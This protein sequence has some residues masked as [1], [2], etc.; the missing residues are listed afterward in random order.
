MSD[1]QLL[2]GQEYEKRLSLVYQYTQRQRDIPGATTELGNVGTEITPTDANASLV[3][4]FNLSEIQAVLESYVLV[5]PGRVNLNLPSELL[6]V[7]CLIEKQSSSGSNS[8]WGLV[9]R[10]G[11]APYS[12]SISSEVS[13]QASGSVMA[14]LAYTWREQDSSDLPCQRFSCFL[15]IPPEGIITEEDILSKVKS[16]NP[17]PWAGLI[18]QWPSF[19][20]EAHTLVITGSSVSVKASV[21]VSAFANDSVGDHSTAY[22]EGSS[23]NLSEGTSASVST[24]S[25]SIPPCIHGAI[26]ISGTSSLTT[27]TDIIASASDSITGGSPYTVPSSSP[28]TKTVTGQVKGQISE[29][30]LAETHGTSTIPTTGLYL[31]DLSVD[32]Y[33]YGMVMVT[34]LV[35]D[36][37]SL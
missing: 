26:T 1:G 15:T 20:P 2:K 11:D 32:V 23:Y 29:T 9:G 30:T 36:F 34:G 3:R 16:L 24:K 27:P 17:T 33:Q 5:V 4:D 37:A 18:G 22:V 19:K 6:G 7:Q 12:A 10:A 21:S 35:F 14:D 8:P 31:K 28:G 25:V 13:S